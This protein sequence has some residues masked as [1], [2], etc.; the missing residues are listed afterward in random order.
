MAD[1]EIV[2]E[3]PKPEGRRECKKSEWE[4]R[5]QPPPEHP[6]RWARVELRDSEADAQLAAGRLRM[7]TVV[8][9]GRWEIT[10]RNLED[11]RGAVYA[12]YLGP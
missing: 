1:D 10:S 12:R 4:V 7:K 11:G 9:D 3:D 8:W 6:N 5:L 2:W